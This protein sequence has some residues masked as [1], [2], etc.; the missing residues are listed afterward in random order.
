MS[1]LP[2]PLEKLLHEVPQA[3]LPQ[4]SRNPLTGHQPQSGWCASNPLTYPPRHGVKHTDYSTPTSRVNLPPPPTRSPWYRCE[5]PQHL[6]P[7]PLPQRAHSNEDVMGSPEC[8]L[9]RPMEYSCGWES[10]G[11]STLNSL[12]FNSTFEEAAYSPFGTFTTVAQQVP[13]TISQDQNTP[14][15]LS[16]RKI[17]TPNGGANQPHSLASAKASIYFPSHRFSKYFH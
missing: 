14:L 13:Q 17:Q 2:T 12:L 10:R 3:N 4:S 8:N 7:S 1:Q 16:T 5:P 6:S 11:P 15:N 9:R